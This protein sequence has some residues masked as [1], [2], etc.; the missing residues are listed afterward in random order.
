MSDRITVTI[1]KKV[2]QRLEDIKESRS[3]P[4]NETIE[5]LLNY[6][7]FG[8]DE[9]EYTEEVKKRLREADKQIAEGKT[10]SLEDTIKKYHIK[11]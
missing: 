5:R 10:I 2:R 11:V 1:H 7:Q 9:G 3:E 6:Y 4:L 8:D